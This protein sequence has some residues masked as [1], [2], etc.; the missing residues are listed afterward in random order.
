MFNAMWPIAKHVTLSIHAKLA[1]QAILLLV[2][3]VFNAMWPI[4]KH[5]VLKT[6]ARLVP[7]VT[8]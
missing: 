2:G 7:Q 6:L 3:L 1:F 8:L 5:A 4:V